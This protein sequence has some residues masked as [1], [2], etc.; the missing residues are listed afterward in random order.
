MQR[1]YRG[2]A[3][4]AVVG[5]GIVVVGVGIGVSV[6][7][8][9]AETEEGPLADAG[10]DQT[11]VQGTTV[12]LDAGGST[13]PDGEIVGYEWEIE[14]PNSVTPPDCRTCEQTQFVATEEGTYT[15][16]MTITDDEGA[17]DTD[18]LYVTVVESEPPTV[19]LAGPSEVDPDTT[20]SFTMTAAAGDAPLS[21]ASW[22]VDGESIDS[23]FIS[24]RTWTRNINFG[25]VGTQTV[26]VVVTDTRGRQARASQSVSITEDDRNN[27]DES[28]SEF[29]VDIQ[30]TNSP[31]VGGE[32]LTTDIAVENNGDA[33]DIQEI[34]LQSIDGTSVDGESVSLDGDE[35]ASITLEWDTESGDT[36]SG[37][38]TAASDDDTDDESVEITGDDSNNGNSGQFSVNIV[39]TNSP[40]EEGETLTVDAEVEN[41]ADVAGEQSIVFESLYG[42]SVDSEPVALE[43]A[44]QTT[45]QLEWETERGDAGSGY[46]NA[47][48][49]DDSD[50]G[51]VEIESDDDGPVYDIEIVDTNSPVNAGETIEVET[52]M[53]NVGGDWDV[54]S[55]SRFADT[56][57][58]VPGIGSTEHDDSLYGTDVSGDTWSSG[59]TITQTMTWDTRGV[60]AGEYDVTSYIHP[61]PNH[62]DTDSDST[63]VEIQEG[64]TNFEVNII[65]YRDPIPTGFSH[66]V[67]FEVTNTGAP[68]TEDV[69]YEHIGPMSGINFD[70]HAD[71]P[72]TIQSDLYLDSGETKAWDSPTG[73]TQVYRTPATYSPGTYTSAINTESDSEFYSF[74]VESD[75]DGG[76]GGS[77]GQG[78]GIEMLMGLESSQPGYDQYQI[79]GNEYDVGGDVVIECG[80]TEEQRQAA[81][82]DDDLRSYCEGNLEGHHVFEHSDI[83]LSPAHIDQRNGNWLFVGPLYGQVDVYKGRRYYD[84]QGDYSP[85]LVPQQTADNANVGIRET[86]IDDAQKQADTTVEILAEDDDRV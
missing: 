62:I 43:S 20:E 57:L 34:I 19:D 37:S 58:W 26:G 82:G 28:D 31:V 23:R 74:S 75:D 40:V 67:R 12:Y 47:R 8:G 36:G 32:T 60:D 53:T 33:E 61:D 6:V 15:V 14:G 84:V 79:V 35:S 39:D 85:T 45:V 17:T 11:V 30:E 25:D 72:E 59:E 7:A 50:D 78:W 22:T 69:T 83:P 52:E 18:T 48:S 10:L 81:D 70:Y 64:E 71:N 2:V 86:I 54:P 65:Q 38:I 73:S 1:L 80:L 3:I 42:E 9:G 13:T 16:S 55:Y 68:G 41:S 4:V 76:P 29:A 56:R 66:Q 51:Y 27:S 24:D 21:S 49:E 44:E 63:Q 77:T 5:I 46:V